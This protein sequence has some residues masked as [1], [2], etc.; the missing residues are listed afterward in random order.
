MDTPDRPNLAIAVRTLV[1]GGF[2]L[3]SVQRN[4][5]YVLLH[6]DRPDEFGAV[7]H[8]CLALA[9]DTFQEVHVAGAK[10]SAEH[11][12]AQL[13][14]IGHGE[15]GDVPS[16][17]WD[18]FLNL[19][20]GPV[21]T[22]TPFEPNFK[23]QLVK[24][25]FNQLPE[26]ME[27]KPDDL[28]E[29]YARIA[30][31]FVL[32]TRVIRYGQDRLF[33]SRPDGIILPYHGFAA[34]YD[35]KAYAKGYTVTLDTIRQFC[36]YVEDFRSRYRLYFQQLSAFI[37]ISSNFPHRSETLAN[38]SRELFATCG[39]PLIFLTSETLG[40]IVA[41]LSTRS[42]ARSA[43]NWRRVFA[44]PIVTAESVQKE[45][46]VVKRDEILRIE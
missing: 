34:L 32:G 40:E 37:V 35:A 22:S 2:M 28:Y 1:A 42:V 27:G 7:H 17:E 31:E 44:E 33:E 15:T 6:M 30:L 25:G 41:Y 38:R 19:F 9:E 24:L 43:I 18:R 5:G 36:S 8:Y 3:V 13:I 45:V 46:E 26:G 16:V 12:H 29:A 21:F 4:P 39:V 10:I 14:L 23:D 11:R 20:G